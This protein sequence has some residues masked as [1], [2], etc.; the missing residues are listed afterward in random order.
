MNATLDFSHLGGMRFTQ[1]AA[2]HMQKSYV[3]AFKAIATAFGTRVIVT[4]VAD[5]GTSWGDGWVVIDGEMMPFVGGLKAGFVSIETVI[6]TREYKDG[7]VRPMYY[8]K[9]A[10]L[11]IVGDI[12]FDS[13]VRISRWVD[14][15][16]GLA[17]LISAHN[18]LALA[19]A[20]HSHSWDQITGKPNFLMPVRW[21]R[22]SIGDVPGE[23]VR[24]V[25]ID[26]LPDN[27]YFVHGSIIGLS[28]NFTR[29]NDTIVT[30]RN[31]LAGSFQ[32]VFSET[33]S[34]NQNIRFDYIIYRL[35]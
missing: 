22:V 23:L 5:N 12:P 34:D 21:G 7:V 35:Q 1:E 20:N 2:A 4:G 27:N 28:A 29:D 16:D 3:D 18:A 33:I 8:T 31:L 17:S 9:R 14:I 6:E 13:L 19:F 25:N 30:Y 15:S 11:G 24:T 32:A 10:R 26:P